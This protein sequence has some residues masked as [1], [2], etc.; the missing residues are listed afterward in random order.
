MQDEVEPLPQRNLSL[1]DIDD[2]SMNHVFAYMD[3]YHYDLFW[4]SLSDSFFMT[5]GVAYVALSLWDWIEVE[6]EH[7]SY[8]YYALSLMV[9]LIYL[10]N[11]FIDITWAANARYTYRIKRNMKLIWK[12]ESS[13][14]VLDAMLDETTDGIPWWHRVRKHAAHRRTVVAALFFGIA[15]GLAV[16]AAVL[17]FY[18]D[19]DVNVS[20]E[21]LDMAS[22]HVYI[23]S[24]IIAITGKR[25]R[26]WLTSPS[27]GCNNMLDNPEPLED[28]GDLLFLMGSLVDGSMWY[29][30]YGEAPVWSFISSLLWFLDACLYLRSDLVMAERTKRKSKDALLV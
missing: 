25:T 3:Y 24:A 10:F 26:P 13:N 23:L 4:S 6:E 16:L 2:L 9:P 17:R 5:G 7:T 19:Q 15:A 20:T 28:M 11:S 18:V 12:Q 29:F 27:Q 14:T 22:D 21:G 30:Q 1:P 8:W